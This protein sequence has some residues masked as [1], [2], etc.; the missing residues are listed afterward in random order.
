MTR[1]GVGRTAMID[2]G[3][4]VYANVAEVTGGFF[5]VLGVQPVLGRALSPADDKEGAENVIVLS[6]GFWQ[7]RYGAS[8]EVIGRRV[9]LDEQSFRIVGVMPADLDYPTGVEVWR[10]T[11]SVPTD[12]PFGD[13]A[14][15]EVNLIARLRPGVTIEQATSEIVA[16]SERLE[17]DAPANAIRGLVPVVRPFADVVVGDVRTPMLALFG[18]VGLVLL[19]ASANVANLLLMRAE[20]RRGELALRAALGAGRGRILSQVLVESLVLAVLGRCCGRCNH[21]VEPPGAD[22]RGAGRAAARGIGPH[23]R[24]GCRVLDWCRPGDGA[25]RGSCAGA[26][27][28]ADRPG[29][30]AASRRQWE[31]P[32]HAASA[33]AGCSSSPRLPWP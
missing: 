24:D 5:D 33:D 31:H 28:D 32:R 6:G 17:A 19:I 13:A 23:R 22:H 15:R 11:S 26:P 16:L 25:A 29:V 30:A 2:D 14:R 20:A 4:S 7:R 12:G 8:R 18:A 3:V 10:T 1:N 21:L 9:T 27:V